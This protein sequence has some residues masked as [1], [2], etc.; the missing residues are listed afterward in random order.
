VVGD[1]LTSPG[2]GRRPGPARPDA[3]ELFAALGSLEAAP[4]RAAEVY[5]ALGY[6]VLPVWPPTPSGCACPRGQRCP[7]PGK[8]PLSALVPHGLHD[9]TCDPAT[10][11]A[12]WQRW[13]GASVALRTGPG[14]FDACDVDGPQG[15][16]ALRAV[17]ANAPAPA[18]PG[19]LARTGGDGWH[20]LY[21]P[22]GLGNRVRLLAGVDWRGAGGLFVV[23]PSL[24]ASGRR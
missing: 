17:L 11:R 1:P 22:T 2:P 20:L 21:R 18:S 23:W 3:G 5:A 12:R 10:V 13:P 16:E 19:P 9:A 6:P 4:G 8:H 7:W 14:S 24:H 15:V